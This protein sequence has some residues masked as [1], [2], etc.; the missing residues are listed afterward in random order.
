[1]AQKNTTVRKAVI[2]AAGFGTRFLPQTKALPKEMLP[3]IDKPIIQ[4]VVERKL[5]NENRF[6][7]IGIARTN[8][9]KFYDNH[10]LDGVNL[11]RLKSVYSNKIEYSNIV[12]INNETSSI[13]VY[14]N[15]VVHQWS[16]IISSNKPMNYKMELIDVSGKLIF[17]F[18]TKNSSNVILNF[19]RKEEWKKG[20]YLLRII[21]QSSGVAE[22]R[23]LLF[24]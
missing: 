2:A 13:G 18:E 5:S 14:P 23:K 9:T 21:N 6:N 20:M 7:P 24:Q 12:S 22:V 3:I 11:Y 8:E 16:V 1:M 10:P 19:N 17:S 4:Y 15:P